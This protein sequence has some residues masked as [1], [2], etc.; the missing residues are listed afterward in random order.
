VADLVKQATDLYKNAKALH[1]EAAVETHVEATDQKRD[2]KSA[3]V[4][5]LEKPNLFSLVTKV[6][7][8][9]NAGPNI[10][11]DGKSLFTHAKRLKQDMEGEAPEDLAGVGRV[12]PSFGHA[13]TGMLFQ[14]LLTDEPYE[15]LMDGVSECS[16]QGKEKVNDQEAHHL[17]FAQPDM[18]W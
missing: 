5:D 9:D 2:I 16:Y 4:Y 10:I 8:D 15:T 1:V 13:S 6:N 11:C 18:K 14:N 12:L 3:A 17:A 7:G